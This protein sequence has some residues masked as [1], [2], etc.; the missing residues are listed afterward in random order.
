MTS[1]G[2][3]MFDFLL[4]L[5]QG[6]VKLRVLIDLDRTILGL[7]RRNQSQFALLLGFRKSLLLIAGFQAR[8]LRLNPDL[9]Q[10]H[11]IFLRRVELAV[12]NAAACGHALA[13]SW[14][15]HRAGS[16]AVLMFKFPIENIGDDLHIAVRMSWKSRIRSYPILV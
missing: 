15:D 16:Q 3:L 12:P 14:K 10:V 4:R 7:L 9:Q 6:N 13:V 8:S 1:L 11:W 2:E 5:E